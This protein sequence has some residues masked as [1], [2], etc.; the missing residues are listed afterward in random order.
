MAARNLTFSKGSGK[1]PKATET[2]ASGDVVS[3]YNTVQGQINA[4]AGDFQRGR[5]F[6]RAAYDALLAQKQQL[7]S[8]HE[9]LSAVRKFVPGEIAQER[10][11]VNREYLRAQAASA[12]ALWGGHLGVDM[13]AESRKAA[14]AARKQAGA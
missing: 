3:R 2:R 11:A 14:K 12:G 9:E 10:Q 6:D 13:R 7:A 5:P 1:A 8:T 4:M